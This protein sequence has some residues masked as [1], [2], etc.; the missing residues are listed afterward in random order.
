MTTEHL[1][2]RLE[3][4]DAVARYCRAIDRRML[5]DLYELY[6]PGGLDHHTGFS[7]TVEQFVPWLVPAT[8]AVAG[9]MH[10]I[11]NHLAEIRGDVAVAETYAIAYHW[12]DQGQDPTANYMSIVRYIDHFVRHEGSW[13]IRER[14]AARERSFSLAGLVAPRLAPGPSGSAGPDDPIHDLLARLRGGELDAPGV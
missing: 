2:D 11:G 9:T 4:A 6:V 12:D 10:L 7:G 14:W 3:I 13:R 1:A 5:D 8:A